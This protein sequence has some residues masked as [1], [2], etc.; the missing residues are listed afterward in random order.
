MLFFFFVICF[1]GSFD[2]YFGRCI[3]S[4]FFFSIINKNN[5]LCI[6][7]N[8]CVVFAYLFFFCLF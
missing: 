5:I 6:Y 4:V 1:S 2:K 8:E 3:L 7:G